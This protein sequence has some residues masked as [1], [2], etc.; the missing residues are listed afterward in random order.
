[1][2]LS[3]T[4]LVLSGLVVS[5]SS[6]TIA[7]GAIFAISFVCGFAFV[8]VL[9]FCLEK[10]RPKVNQRKAHARSA[11]PGHAREV[12]GISVLQ[13]S[14]PPSGVYPTLP[15]TFA[16]Q[17]EYGFSTASHAPANGYQLRS[18]YGNHY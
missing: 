9:V 15:Y 2:S 10:F 17:P 18:D 14:A 5:N 8:L 12:T 1:M 13:S 4:H 3:L 11:R 6:A 7:G 16:D